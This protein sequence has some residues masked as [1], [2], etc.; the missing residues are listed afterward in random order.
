MRVAAILRGRDERRHTELEGSGKRAH[1]AN[2]GMTLSDRLTDIVDGLPV[3][4][5]LADR[6]WAER[7]ASN[8][9]ARRYDRPRDSETTSSRESDCRG[10][11]SM[12]PRSRSTPIAAVQA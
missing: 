9:L 6:T 12:R 8:P 10:R 3:R 11:H 7:S 1:V 5:A 4:T 2:V